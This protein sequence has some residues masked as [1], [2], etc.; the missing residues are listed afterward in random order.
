MYIICTHALCSLKFCKSLKSFVYAIYKGCFLSWTLKDLDFKILCLSK[1]EKKDKTT[2]QNKRT[3]NSS[4][5]MNA[6]M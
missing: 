5:K 2:K 6:R 4:L 3:L 1:C